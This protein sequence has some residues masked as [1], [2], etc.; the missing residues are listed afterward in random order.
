MPEEK[1]VPLQ[2]ETRPE[3]EVAVGVHQQLM[4]RFGQWKKSVWEPT[5]ENV[6][7]LDDKSFKREVGALLSREIEDPELVSRRVKPMIGF[8]DFP[9]LKLYVKEGLGKDQAFRQTLAHEMLHLWFG[10][11]RFKDDKDYQASFGANETFVE[12]LSLEAM[13]FY[14][15]PPNKLEEPIDNAVAN[16]SIIREVVEKIGK[17][18]W[19]Y[20]FDTCQTGNQRQIAQEMERRFGR[21]PPGRFA[22]LN[23]ELPV[24]FGKDFWGRLKELALM[25]DLFRQDPSFEE[26]NPVINYQIL[27]I[28][29]WSGIDPQAMMLYYR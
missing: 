29:G 10:R 25:L 21:K 18:G 19:R 23:E 5:E 9:S 4:E 26:K 15:L 14:N 12:T 1:E 16:Y 24:V 27:L 6:L 11:N 22:D 20:L 3:F 2:I 17:N 7:I 8:A 13:G 28:M